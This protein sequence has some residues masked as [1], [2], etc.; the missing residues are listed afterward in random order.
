M[1]RQYAKCDVDAVMQIWLDTNLQAH[2]FISPNY[3]RNNYAIVRELL[4]H[5]EI[6]VHE[7]DDTNQIDGF[8]GLNDNYIEG[9]FV[10]EI[11]QSMGVGKQ[12]LNYVKKEK[13]ILSLSVYK[14][15]TKAVHFYLR[16][17]FR[18]QSEHTDGNTGETEFLMTWNK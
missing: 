11:I 9:L 5:A 16:E 8:I 17:N 18:I 15:N 2:N 12:L 4:P 7:N 14:K 1:I 10:K 6:Y 3:W 13:I